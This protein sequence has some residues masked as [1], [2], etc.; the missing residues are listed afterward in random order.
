[1]T[2]LL[3][4][5]IFGV[6]IGGLYGLGA[7][8]LSLVFGVLRIL[9]VAHGEL[10]MLG[11]YLSF[12]LFTLEGVDPFLS[13]LLSGP[14]LFAVG[15]VLYQGVFRHIARFPTEQKI[16]NSILIGFGLALV[17]HTLAI[18]AWEAD[19]RIITPVYA[20]RVLALGSL[21][22]PLSRLGTL[23]V[24]FLVLSG[25]HGFLTRTKAGVAIRATA[26]DPQAAALSGIAVG[27]ISLVA[28]ALG[29]GLAGVAGALISVSDAISPAIGLS[30]TLKS[31]IVIVLGGMGNVFG[32]FAAGLFLGAAEAASGFLLGNLY[33]EVAGLG[34]FLLA[35]SIRPQGLFA[36]G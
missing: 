36:R 30:W 17:L 32:T 23:L 19:E 31:L 16:K 26:A 29:S 21:V 5:I 34:L 33:R 25:L 18:L 9:N 2:I 24:A 6:L 10:I 13:I 35:L 27:R 3:Q 15:A 20:G 11:G 12:W 1:M 22:V 7:V 28:F 8:G 4:N 14:V